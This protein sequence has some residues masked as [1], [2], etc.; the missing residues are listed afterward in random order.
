MMGAEGNKDSLLGSLADMPGVDSSEWK[1][2]GGTT[3]G[4][5]YLV[6]P[7]V[8]V[9]VPVPGYIQRE[10]DARRSL[11]EFHRI[12]AEAGR[13]HAAII[14]V[15][16]VKAQDASSRRVWSTADDRGKRSAL[17]LVCASPLARAIGSFFIG[18][19]RPSVPTKM[20]RDFT[21]ARAWCRRRVDQDWNRGEGTQ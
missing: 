1:W 4:G 17:A 13:P 3:A 21:S 2:V 5:Y 10:A 8:V 15:D 7:G 14:L 20:F 19:N 6:E 16:R 18:F 11:D 9:A 12:V